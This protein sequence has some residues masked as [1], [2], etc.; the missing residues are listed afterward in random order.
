MSGAPGLSIEST[1]KLFGKICEAVNAAHLRGVI[2]RDLKPG[3]SW[4]SLKHQATGTSGD[5]L[6]L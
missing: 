2:H 4:Y 3:N 5:A 1:L 6:F